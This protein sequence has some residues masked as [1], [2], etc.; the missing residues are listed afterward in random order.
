MLELAMTHRATALPLVV[1]LVG[2]LLLLVATIQRPDPAYGQATIPT[3]VQWPT[4]AGGNGHWY[5]P[6]LAP[7]GSAS[8]AT[9]ATAIAAT[10]PTRPARPRMIPKV[11]FTMLLPARQPPERLGNGQSFCVR[12]G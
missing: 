12:S 3:A 6:V 2:S 5:L 4:A 8:A 10:S 1:I 9:V 7:A 11:R